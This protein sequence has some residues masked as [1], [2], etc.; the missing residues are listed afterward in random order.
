MLGSGK[1]KLR[2]F[3][4]CKRN[5]LASFQNGGG[6]FTW[7]G[8]GHRH[9]RSDLR[10]AGA[11]TQAS[12]D[13]DGRAIENLPVAVPGAAGG[14]AAA[15]RVVAAELPKP[16]L[17]APLDAAVLV[18]CGLGHKLELL[19]AIDFNE[20]EVELAGDSKAGTVSQRGCVGAGPAPQLP[21]AHPTAPG[22][23]TSPCHHHVS[24]PRLCLFGFWFLSFQGHT[25]YTWRFPG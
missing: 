13:L 1:M 2:G 20:S 25:R 23:E 7:G 10:P 24:P 3:K 12:P 5:T 11:C 21:A 15:R 22:P 14:G 9:A 18:P 19:D 8:A 6:T 4:T 16:L 17:P